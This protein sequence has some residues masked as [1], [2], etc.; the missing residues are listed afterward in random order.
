MGKRCIIITAYLKNALFDLYTPREGDLVLCAD[1]GYAHAARAGLIP[2]RVIGDLDSLTGAVP[3]EAM[4]ELVPV[5]KDD[6]DTM[7]C[8][9]RALAH[10]CGECVILG[11]IG[12]RLDHTLA[13]LQTL[14]FAVSN[15]MRAE[16][17]GDDDR[18]ILLKDGALTL[19]R[20]ESCSLSL[21]SFT[22]RCTGVT[23]S[24]VKYPLTGATIT[25]SNPMA[26]SNSF[27]AEEA[28]IEVKE[29]MLL[30][31]LSHMAR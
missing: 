18:A 10:G 12:G 7:L 16:L 8:A 23:T 2:D 17:A 14:A 30:I 4:L 15:G 5:E 31:V 20:E 25:Q 1:G 26:V 29:G 22:E 11:G 28:H 19:H 9:R 3:P 27:T 13:N 6:T 24:G 21:L